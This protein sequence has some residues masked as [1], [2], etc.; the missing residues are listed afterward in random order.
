MDLSKKS[1]TV[2]RNLGRDLGIK[3]ATAKT[4]GELLSAIDDVLSGK[5]PYDP[6]K[7]IRRGRS[8]LDNTPVAV[9]YKDGKIILADQSAPEEPIINS[10]ED[11]ARYREILLAAQDLVDKL[12]ELG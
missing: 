12:K 1:L 6:P 3:S 11:A 5:V 10:P 2:L 7:D 8:E 9:F 4:R